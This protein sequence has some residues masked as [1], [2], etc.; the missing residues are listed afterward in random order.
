VNP[1]LSYS[2][3]FY[4]YSVTSLNI[5]VFSLLAI[6]FT[7]R[8]GYLSAQ[9]P[10]FIPNKGLQAYWSFNGTANDASGNNRHG[11]VN[12][13]SL[14][15]DRF[16]NA[17]S[18]YSFNGFSSFITT[19]Y[20]GILGSKPRAV[21]FWAKTRSRKPVSIISWGS[22]Q[23]YPTN[24]HRFDCGFNYIEYGPNIDIADASI[25]YEAN[26]YPHDGEWHH[27]IYQFTIPVLK[28]IEI[29]QDGMLL[30][31]SA[32]KFYPYTFVNTKAL[33]KLI[34]GCL[35]YPNEG[36]SLVDEK[37]AEKFEKKWQE[38]F[39]V[40][41]LKPPSSAQYFH[42]DKKHAF[43]FEGQLDD[44]AIYDRA[45]SKKE[46]LAL[47]NA[48]NPKPD[49]LLRAGKWA[50]ILATLIL[51]IWAAMIYVKFRIRKA[52]RKETE[53]NYLRNNAY[54]QQNK[55]LKAQMDPHFIFNSLNTIQQFIV[56]NDNEK[57]Q[58][59]L[60]KFSRLMRQMIESNLKDSISLEEEIELCERYLE[61]E[62][63]R[64][65]N[66]FNYSISAPAGKDPSEIFI[67]HFLIQ[68]F[69]ENAIWHALLPKK[70]HKQ[71][72]IVFKIVDENTLSCSIDDNGVGRKTS[73]T[74]TNSTN[75]KSLAINFIKQR[76]DLMS[77]IRQ[78]LYQMSIIDKVNETGESEGTR[79][80][81][82]M[83]I[84]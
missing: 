41:K 11:N 1:R 71:I 6:F 79:V 22:N 55:V 12:Q 80:V 47:Y 30:T 49:I 36:S 20:E 83:P 82:T 53:K 50:L 10:E 52:L 24:G 2:S 7:A 18:A 72:D 21:S 56:T 74:K 69:I 59:Y 60:Y 54:E 15:A 66:I 67:P 8:T 25:T 76:L 68:P 3:F 35:F 48:P 13:V 9:L 4:I 23:N 73:E 61:I 77:K 16:G 78:T 27:Y 17:N 46:I 42:K 19:N 43:F 28:D 39:K 34:F 26:N 38:A 32:H 40:L 51:I 45:L 75:K 62:S 44:I 63:L 57:A 58:H 33:D 37:D 81:I 64:F 29:Y 65:D 31:H 70:G 84:M 5:K 14:T